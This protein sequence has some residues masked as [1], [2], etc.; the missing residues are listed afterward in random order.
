[1][2]Y[3]IFD[4]DGTL[5]DTSISHLLAL[6]AVQKEFILNKNVKLGGDLKKNIYHLVQNKID[7][8]EAVRIY[9]R[10]FIQNIDKAVPLFS[11]VFIK[12]LRNTILLT[13]R[14]YV[15]TQALLNKFFPNY[16][17]FIFT[18]DDRDKENPEQ[19]QNVLRHI[20]RI[21][22]YDTV[23][24]WGDSIVDRRLAAKIGAIYN[25]RSI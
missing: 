19:I 15:T 20:I 11:E 13:G 25:D 18:S 8:S 7:F 3:H 2:E 21:N 14:D 12:N 5:I 16:F 4:L 9:Q 24:Y 23:Q 10:Y 1:M 17:R 22:T 6:R